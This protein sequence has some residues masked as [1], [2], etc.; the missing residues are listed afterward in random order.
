MNKILSL[1]LAMLLLQMVCFVPATIARPQ[2]DK[3]A[4]RIAR[5]KENVARRGTGERARVRVTLL[6]GRKISGYISEVRENAFVLIDQQTNASTTLAY[7][8]VSQ[9]KGRGLSV[10]AKVGIVA[11]VAATIGIVVAIVA[12]Q[13]GGT[14]LRPLPG[15]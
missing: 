1:M 8:D 4:Q 6:D 9:V 12:N 14:I 5:I 11:A 15:Q 7:T 10:L 2:T 3:D 13:E